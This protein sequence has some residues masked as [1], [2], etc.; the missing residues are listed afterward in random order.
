MQNKGLT[1]AARI[2]GTAFSLA[3]AGTM[4]LISTANS[5]HTTT[6][7]NTPKNMVTIPPFC[8]LASF[9]GR[10]AGEMMREAIV[11][12]ARMA[13][14]GWSQREVVAILE[15]TATEVVPG[16]ATFPKMIASFGANA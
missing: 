6:K 2:P 11:R 8:I 9:G 3:S 7:L 10:S 4:I 13:A 1:Q 14:T 16:V 5:V 12:T 15:K